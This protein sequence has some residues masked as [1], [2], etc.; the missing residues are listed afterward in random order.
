MALEH[1]FMYDR[2]MTSLTPEQMW[3]KSPYQFFLMLHPIRD[4]QHMDTVHTFVQARSIARRLK[5]AGRF[6]DSVQTHPFCQEILEDTLCGYEDLQYSYNY[7][8]ENFSRMC[9]YL[10]RGYIPEVR[11]KVTNWDSVVG[12]TIYNSWDLDPQAL[13]HGDLSKELKFMTSAAM[14]L[15]KRDIPDATLHDVATIFVR[16]L[17]SVGRE[18]I[19]DL[20]LNAT[21]GRTVE[22]RISLLLPHQNET[23]IDTPVT[24][25]QAKSIRVN[26]I[27][28]LNGL[29]RKRVAKFQ[30]TYY[31]LCV[32]RAENCR[33][34]YVIFSPSTT[35]V[36]FMKTYLVRFNRRHSKFIYE[37][38]VGKGSFNRTLAYDLGM[39]QLKDDELALVATV[40]LSVADHFLGRCRVN[41]VQGRR[42]YYPE[43]FTYYNMPYVYRGKWHPRNYEYS[44][45]HGRWATHAVGCIYKSDYTEVGGYSAFKRWELDPLEAPLEG[46]MELM[47]APDP[48]VSHW[49]EVTRCDSK[50][51][52][53]Q[54]SRCLSRQSD[55]LAD[56]LSLAGYLLA[57]EEKCGDDGRS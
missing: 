44:R 21:R 30:R 18:F 39:G 51:P 19:L 54:F 47:R 52:P 11:R 23:F 7:S 50:L 14:E 2:N 49:Y 13:V 6:Q 33:V 48:G 56:R 41:T 4:S 29:D 32:R 35:D 45:M 10:R 38:V 55:N 43:V 31:T 9:N 20:V 3:H 25:S 46:R 17:G 42:I 5:R 36:N 40:D 1:Y 22:R 57:L 53:N 28:P 27:V 16:Y 12:H 8:Y 15:V 37:Y 24:V 34:V 26:F